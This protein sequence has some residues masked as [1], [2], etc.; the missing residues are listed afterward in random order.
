LPDAG[1]FAKNNAPEVTV[2]LTLA[3]VFLSC[4]CFSFSDFF[5]RSIGNIRYFMIPVTKIVRKIAVFKGV[6]SKAFTPCPTRATATLLPH[7]PATIR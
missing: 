7:S 1:G 5:S 4:S 6:G 3:R 2:L